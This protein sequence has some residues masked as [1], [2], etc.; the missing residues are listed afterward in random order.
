MQEQKDEIKQP[1]FDF[2]PTRV[3]IYGGGGLS[4]MIIEAVRVLGIYQIEGIVDDSM[5]KGT[6]VIGS[7][8]LGGAEILP[9][10]YARGIRMAVN[11]VG[12]IGDFQVRLNVFHTLANAGFVCPAIVHPTAHVDPSARLAPGVL[13]LAQSYVSGNA[14]VGMGTLINN[15]VVVSHDN[16]IGVCVNLSPGAMLAGDVVID[17]YAQLGMNVNV[18]IGVHI[19]KYARIANGATIKGNVPQGGRVYAGTVWPPRD[20]PK[21]RTV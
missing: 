15:S 21:P 10:L 4:K 14:R 3:I 7:P 16:V 17:D 19:G 13:V 9:Q 6:D 5:E 12:G 1:I 2:D 8:V 18:N 11:S 20:L